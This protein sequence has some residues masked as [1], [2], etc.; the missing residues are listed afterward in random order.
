MFDFFKKYYNINN[1]TIAKLSYLRIVLIPISNS[2]KNR[3]KQILFIFIKE[4]EELCNVDLIIF[5]YIKL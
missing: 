4:I 1:L 2:I 5:L 3:I